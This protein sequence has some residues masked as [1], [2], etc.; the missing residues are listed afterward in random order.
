M[1][2]ATSAAKCIGAFV[3]MCATALAVRPAAAQTNQ[4]DC[5][6][7]DGKVEREINGYKIQVDP[8][9]GKRSGPTECRGRILDPRGKAIY[10]VQDRGVNIVPVSGD[11]IGGD[12]TPD[13]VFEGY[14]GGAHCCWT[15]WIY[16]LGEP[17]KLLRKIAGNK[18][19]GFVD[20]NG[21]GHVEIVAQ[22]GAFDYFDSLPHYQSPAPE[23]ILRLNGNKLE[24][25]DAEF[26]PRYEKRIASARAA[27]I[28]ECAALYKSL[29]LG[30]KK[31]KRCDIN[32]VRL[33]IL[34]IVLN[35]LY[36]G[37]EKE[38]WEEL[39]NLWPEKDLQ[40]MHDLIWKTA[41]NSFL[42]DPSSPNYGASHE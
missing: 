5:M 8:L 11:N 16:E 29:D 34:N 41:T 19:L 40:R 6:G 28:P 20:L 3:L 30:F 7:G 32:N 14:S 36:G 4:R 42:G 15:Y 18:G 35:Y 17:P 22:D 37:H 31:D 13:L 1:R 12:G 24:R 10:T 38:A 39:A 2:S 23:V 9:P 33:Q 27:L 26:W 25:V 21:D